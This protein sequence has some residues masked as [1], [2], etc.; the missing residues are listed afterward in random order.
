MFA[1]ILNRV[2]G[3]VKST[4]SHWFKQTCVR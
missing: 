4:A 2:D 1:I 3:D